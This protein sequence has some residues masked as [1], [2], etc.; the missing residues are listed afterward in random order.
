MPF[1][2]IIHHVNTTKLKQRNLSM[3]LVFG[4]DFSTDSTLSKICL[5][6]Q[7]T[8]NLPGP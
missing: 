4:L 1:Y 5:K 6:F 8:V 3:F 2:L 7:T